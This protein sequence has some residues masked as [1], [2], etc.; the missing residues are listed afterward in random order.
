[1]PVTDCTPY[2]I[3][4]LNNLQEIILPPKGKKSNCHMEEHVHSP[5][6]SKAKIQGNPDRWPKTS[7]SFTSPLPYPASKPESG[8]AG[9]ATQKPQTATSFA[10]QPTEVGDATTPMGEFKLP[11]HSV[12]F[13]TLQQT[14]AAPS[15]QYLVYFM[16]SSYDYFSSPSLMLSTTKG[17]MVTNISINSTEFSGGSIRDEEHRNKNTSIPRR[18]YCRH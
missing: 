18:K 11:P 6:T 2:L 17:L 15:P 3:Y 10:P 9:G 16:V 12:R 4:Y 1:M 7:L 5:K 13:Q 8:L 14:W